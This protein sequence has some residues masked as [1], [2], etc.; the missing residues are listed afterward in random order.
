MPSL[1]AHTWRIG[2]TKQALYKR[3]AALYKRQEALDGRQ[4]ALYK[5]KNGSHTLR[6]RFPMSHTPCGLTISTVPPDRKSLTR[7]TKNEKGTSHK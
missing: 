4:V 6:L 2:D 7:R 1:Y 5:T 3:Q